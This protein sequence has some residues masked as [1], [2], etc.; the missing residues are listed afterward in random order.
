MGVLNSLKHT[1][2]APYVFFS[3]YK[4]NELA[5]EQS[6]RGCFTSA[7]LDLLE[8]MGPNVITCSEII[9][10]LQKTV[11]GRVNP[12][13]FTTQYLLSIIVAL[14]PSRQSPQCEG[15]HSEKRPIFQGYSSPYTKKFFALSDT[16]GLTLMGGDVH[17]FC[18]GD[19]LAVYKNK[20][21]EHQKEPIAIVEITEA[22]GD[23][24]AITMVW[25]PDS[26][27]T[28][29]LKAY[30]DAAALLKTTA[31]SYLKVYVDQED[32]TLLN[33]IKALGLCILVDVRSGAHIALSVDAAAKV[34]R[35]EVVDQDLLGKKPNLS[36]KARCVPDTDEDLQHVMRG[37]SHYYRHLKRTSDSL[38]D[39]IKKLSV[40]FFE[41]RDT[42]LGHP[43]VVKAD[44]ARN[45]CEN[46]VIDIEVTEDSEA[47]YGFEVTNNTDHNEILFPVLFYFDNT[48]F[49][50]CELITHVLPLWSF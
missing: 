3:A 9:A 33:R 44:N 42:H 26:A 31:Q 36:F 23:T 8:Q 43:R 45:L 22:F 28:L 16:Q 49:T 38:D 47:I 19:Q 35:F 25:V 20:S 40:S 11:N 46:G 34:L 10:R 2:T 21:E 39:S 29:S 7:L 30:P 37:L 17:G 50:I 14:C 12:V 48:D 6:K 27:P 15:M 4:S 41:L 1:G 32:L 18:R 5:K 24:S 13:T